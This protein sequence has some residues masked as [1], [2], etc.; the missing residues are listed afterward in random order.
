MSS[1]NIPVKRTIYLVALGTN[2]LHLSNYTWAT[3][4]APLTRLPLLLL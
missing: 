4:P 3:S 2:T 1:K